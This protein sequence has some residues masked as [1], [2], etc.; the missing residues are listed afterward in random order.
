MTPER[1]T[2]AKRE[3]CSSDNYSGLQM[4]SRYLLKFH[5]I[6][7]V[8][9]TKL[10]R[11]QGIDLELHSSVWE[12]VLLT[13]IKTTVKEGDLWVCWNDV[14]IGFHHAFL[15]MFDDRWCDFYRELFKQSRLHYTT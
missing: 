12:D 14:H 2:Y 13:R 7:D 11:L 10:P 15:S 9:K 6:L 5:E 1:V 4:L 3:L 8:S